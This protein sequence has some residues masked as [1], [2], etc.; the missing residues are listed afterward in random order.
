MTESD[1]WDAVIVAGGAGTRLGGVS[2]PELVIGKAALLD[3]AIAAVE[4]ARSLVMVGGPRVDGIAWTVEE[5]P[6][7]GPA[8]AIAA[9]L[10]R[11][12]DDPS[13]WTLV[14][15]VDTPIASAAVPALLASRER[16]GAWLVDG[17]GH[18]QPIVAVYKTAAMRD[19]CA[20]LAA[21]GL[22][23]GASIRALT[24]ELDMVSVADTHGAA[25][26]VDTWED[27]TYWEG[28]L[29]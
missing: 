13:P 29:G 25:R 19:A 5:P 14:L 6:G 21:S 1:A 20:A 8:A 7:S 22:V 26:D 11:V 18:E 3:R 9:G 24:A 4:G 16:D 15:G 10:A 2:K 27:V 17:D 28:V 12:A 23:N